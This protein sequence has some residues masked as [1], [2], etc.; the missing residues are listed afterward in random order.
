M[1]VLDPCALN[2]KQRPDELLGEDWR[3]LAEKFPEDFVQ[4]LVRAPKFRNYHGGRE[5]QG[6]RWIC[7][8]C[9]GPKRVLFYPIRPVN[10]LKDV[11]VG[12][13]ARRI[14]DEEKEAGALAFACKKC[15]EVV[16][17]TRLDSSFWNILI[18]QLTGGLLY[19]AEVERPGWFV[20]KRKRAFAERKKREVWPTRKRALEMILEGRRAREIA[21]ELGLKKQTINMYAHH[22]YKKYGVHGAGELREKF[23]GE[24]RTSNIEH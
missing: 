22:W 19:G 7:P 13:E 3:D 4:T 8:A 18:G 11:D 23:C 2:G 6:W 10:L 20:E 1:P 14:W 12:E 5:F 21:A 16:H 15:H 9:G 17:F 24:R